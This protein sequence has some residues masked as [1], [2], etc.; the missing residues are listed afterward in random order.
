[1]K[2][3]ILIILIITASFGFILHNSKVNSGTS[4]SDKLIRFHVIANSDSD[5]D[6]R[7]KLKVRDAIL[8]DIGPKLEKSKSRNESLKII[9]ENRGQIERIAN[10]VLKDNHEK[11]TAKAVIGKFTFPIKTYGTITLPS[12]EYTALRVVLGNGEGRNWWCVMFPPLCFIDITRGLTDEKSNEELKRVLNND[13]V[14]TITTFTPGVDKKNI[15][16][17]SQH[18]NNSVTTTSSEVQSN[19]VFKYK[20]VEVFEEVVDKIKAFID[21]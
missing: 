2:K 13:E 7:V 16:N 14:D 3:L 9:E 10:N 18:N 8:S 5:Y 12:G 4:I 1:M 17:W 11:Y 15:T 20:S 6:Q 19:V 21:R